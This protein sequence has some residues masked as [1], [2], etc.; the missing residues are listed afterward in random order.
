MTIHQRYAIR[1]MWTLFSL[2]IVALPFYII[3]ATLPLTSLIIG[4]IGIVFGAL[5]LGVVAGYA[6]AEMRTT[7]DIKS[8]DS[9]LD[10]KA[11]F[12]SR[13]C[14]WAWNQKLLLDKFFDN[15][16]EAAQ[17]KSNEAYFNRFNDRIS[18]LREQKFIP[19]RD[20]VKSDRLPNIKE[21]EEVTSL[22]EQAQKASH[23]TSPK[24]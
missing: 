3:F 9:H 2:A 14:I 15:N 8:K 12:V 21:E 10:P 24:P 16:I 13:F 23:E 22:I 7:H 18:K 17:R 1:G 5:A 4:S 20:Q 19:V 6:L 11:N